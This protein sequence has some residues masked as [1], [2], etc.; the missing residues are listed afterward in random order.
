MRPLRRPIRSMVGPE[1]ERADRAHGEAG[2]EAQEC[3]HKRRV[4]VVA[5]EER[6]RDLSGV[7]A[8][9]EEVVHLEEIAAGDAQDGLQLVE[10]RPAHVGV[11]TRRLPEASSTIFRQAAAE[12]AGGSNNSVICASLNRCHRARGHDYVSSS[13]TWRLWKRFLQRTQQIDIA[14]TW[15]RRSKRGS[16]RASRRS[17][18]CF[19]TVSREQARVRSRGRACSIAFPRRA[20]SGSALARNRSVVCLRSQPGSP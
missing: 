20:R 15:G 13:S 2:G 11:P 17:A 12:R 7:D 18:K 1:H 3:R 16:L 9:Q 14:S 10:T 5:R 6:V 8:E 19:V 4:G